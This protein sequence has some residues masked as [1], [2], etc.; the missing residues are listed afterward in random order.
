MDTTRFNSSRFIR[1]LE[2]GGGRAYLDGSYHFRCLANGLSLHGGRAT[3]SHN[4]QCSRL[5]APYV[6]FVVLLEGSLDFAI[7]QKRYRI[8]AESGKVVL[9]ATAQEILFRRY[10]HKGETT[11]KLSLK[12]L[13]GRLNHTPALL[14]HACRENVRI[15]PLSEHIRKLVPPCLHRPACFADTLAQEAASLQLA[16]ALW[17]EFC[18][19]FPATPAAPNTAS[20]TFGSLLDQAYRQGARHVS[21]LASALH[22]SERTLQRRLQQHMGMTASEWLRHKHMH[23]ALAALSDG[24]TSIGEI[25]YRCGYR[26]VSAFTQAFKQYF[27]CTPAQWRQQNG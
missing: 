4:L 19:F 18:R 24:R 5:A 2:Q 22:M 21:A 14:A 27:D 26:H 12:G 11:A 13:E 10:L 17:Q 16:A 7:N 20:H 6:N 25:A 23:Y 15:W 1:L 3:A 8:A 9:V